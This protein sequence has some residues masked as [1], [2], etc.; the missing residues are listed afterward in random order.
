MLNN[1]ET[2]GQNVVGTKLV[3]IFTETVL[4]LINT[5]QITWE[6]NSGCAQKHM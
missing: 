5:E 6:L 2:Y 4:T 1:C 3:C